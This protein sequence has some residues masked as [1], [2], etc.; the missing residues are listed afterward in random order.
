[1]S[2][3]IVPISSLPTLSSL[4][5]VQG[6]QDLHKTNTA[7]VPFADMLSNAF[8][9]LTQTGATAQKDMYSL[10]VGG[11][12]DLH[13]SSVD[14]VKSGVAVSFASSLTS[15]AIRAYNELMRMQV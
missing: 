7:G 6:K 5:D 8:A 15:A 4:G 9:D 2:N 12:D 10:A 3:F 11:T 1:M 13:T 14:A